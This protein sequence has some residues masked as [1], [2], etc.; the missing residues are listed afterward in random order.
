MSELS[1]RQRFSFARFSLR[2]LF[3]LI[4]AICIFLGYQWEWIRQRR[5]FV[6]EQRDSVS[7]R[8]SWAL[9][10]RSGGIDD[11]QAKRS[12]HYAF[13][14]TE[15]RGPRL[16]WLVGE[17]G[18]RRFELEIPVT[19]RGISE[20]NDFYTV[21]SSHPLLK[22][23]RRL[24]PEAKVFPIVRLSPQHVGATIEVAE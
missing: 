20:R 11:K 24:F 6:D 7:V 10:L 9:H 2:T 12:V 8:E 23:A 5:S 13:Y 16:L 22:R 21:P 18:V 17:R 14:Y 19:D 4:T 3:V 1:W 15:P